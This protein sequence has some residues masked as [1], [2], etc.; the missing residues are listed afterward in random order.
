MSPARRPSG[1]TFEERQVYMAKLF[2]GQRCVLGASLVMPL[3]LLWREYLHW[4]TTYHDYNPHAGT[5]R[6]VLEE[7]PW[8]CVEER[9][10]RGTFK[11]V[12]MGVGL[13][14]NGSMQ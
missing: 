13:K 2:I 8:A 9:S 7:A 4:C 14:P 11:T 3:R 12:V 6:R 1:M 10:G 5:F